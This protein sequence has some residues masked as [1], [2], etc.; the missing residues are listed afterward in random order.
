MKTTTF[1]LGKDMGHDIQI[2]AQS[3]STYGE[4]EYNGK[5]YPR[6]RHIHMLADVR[7]SDGNYSHCVDGELLERA[8]A[9]YEA[10]RDAY[11]NYP[12]GDV[13]VSMRI[14]DHGTNL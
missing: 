11:S 12:D 5:K 1:K 7:L 10:M 13:E 14:V 6:R 2:T 9:V 3:V 8:L 4:S